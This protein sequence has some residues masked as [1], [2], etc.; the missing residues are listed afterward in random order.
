MSQVERASRPGRRCIRGTLDDVGAHRR[1]R[2]D[3]HDVDDE[4]RSARGRPGA[5]SLAGGRMRGIRGS[6]VVCGLLVSVGTCRRRGVGIAR[7]D[8]D[9]TDDR[10]QRD[11]DE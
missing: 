4:H 8:T 5:E 1:Q 2:G 7:Q 3:W 11:G 6:M 10:R 9:M